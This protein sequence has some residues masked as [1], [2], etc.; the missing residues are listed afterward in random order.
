LIAPCCRSTSGGKTCFLGNTRPFRFLARLA[1]RP[2]AYIP[3]ED[4]LSDV[5]QGL[6]SDSAVRS[7]AKA[8]RQRLRQAGLGDLADA[9]DGTVAGHYTLRLRL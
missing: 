8:L 5:W 4:L 7:V 3:Y 6:L 1:Q 2:N 9:I